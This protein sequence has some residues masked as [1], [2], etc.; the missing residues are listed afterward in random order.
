MNTPET[1]VRIVILGDSLASASGDPKGMG[2]I[3][4]VMAR[5]PVEHP[6][7]DVFALPN[8]GET[9]AGL[10]ARYASE[11]QSRF[12][13]D[14]ENRLILVLPN[15]DPSAG[16]SISRSRLN[17]ATVLDEAKRAGIECF[18]V[19]PTPH[20]NPEL[21]SE[22]EHLVAGFEDVCSRRGITFVDCFTPL[23][24]HEAW[25][26]EISAS[27]AGRPG[28]IG[29]GLIAWLILNRGWYEWLGLPVPD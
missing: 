7:I 15:S 20:R 28:Q 11:A 16:L 17:I 21:N 14:A 26:S 4:R 6:Q 13:P 24:E 12:S 19:G 29:H 25:N 5:T 27:A 23:V 2:W 8:P 3:G 1:A 22:I 9:T 18:V 10:A